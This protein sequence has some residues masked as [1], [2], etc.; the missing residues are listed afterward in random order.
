MN[1]EFLAAA[2]PEDPNQLLICAHIMRSPKDFT[3]ALYVSVDGGQSWKL[4]KDFTNYASDPSCVYGLDGVVYAT[5]IRAVKEIGDTNEVYWSYDKGMT[6][7]GPTRMIGADRMYMAV[8]RTNGPNRG[9]LY[10]A[11]RGFA[12]FNGTRGRTKRSDMS[13]F[14]SDSVQ[15]KIDG[16]ARWLP[17]V[18]D[19][20]LGQGPVAVLSDGTAVVLFGVIPHARDSAGNFKEKLDTRPN[21]I[22]Y[23][24]IF[25]EDRIVQ[26]KKVS[27]FYSTMM[28]SLIWTTSA[29]PSIAVD[30]SNG[31]FRDR[32]YAVWLDDRRGRAQVY[33][34][35]S[36][37][38]GKSWTSPRLVSDD[39]LD[40]NAP[41]RDHLL[42]VVAVNKNGVVGIA[43][44][45]RRDSPD[46]Y[47]W[48]ARFTASNDGGDT[49][50]P[51][52]RVSSA[53]HTFNR[54]MFYEQIGAARKRARELKV[55]L[56]PNI[57]S[58]AALGVLASGQDTGALVA[59]ANGAFHVIWLSNAQSRLK[60]LW[61]ATVT[62]IE[63]TLP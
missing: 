17:E 31:R 16:P 2:N 19:E 49:F 12:R 45:D 50:A 39:T 15:K 60:Q 58:G 13:L 48:N 55:K 21:A 22:L 14:W 35:W 46:N 3:T 61:T 44:Y 28:T 1:G 20:P 27:D 11:T 5:V 41:R 9:R 51:S 24:A 54:K 34:A 8:D 18:G 63:Q 57:D 10:I 37:N 26:V 62:V 7:Q 6:W 59:D 42:P 33:L 56:T 52:V 47:G 23:S 36:P 32:I 38:K 30:A 43:W 40:V 4:T 25:N 53:P 29:N